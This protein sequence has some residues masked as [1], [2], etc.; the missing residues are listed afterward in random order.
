MRCRGRP[1]TRAD[2]PTAVRT[3]G[4]ATDRATPILAV[5]AGDGGEESSEFEAPRPL[6]RRSLFPVPAP[7]CPSAHLP[8]LCCTTEESGRKSRLHRATPRASWCL[9]TR[10]DPTC[11]SL[12]GYPNGATRRTLGS[13]DG[14]SREGGHCGR[15][16]RRRTVQE[17]GYAH[18]PRLKEHV[19]EV[20]SVNSA[21]DP[22]PG[23]PGGMPHVS[24]VPSHLAVCRNP[25]RFP[26]WSSLEGSPG[27]RLVRHG[28]RE[29]RGDDEW[30][31]E[32][33]AVRRL[34]HHRIDESPLVQ[35]DAAEPADAESARLRVRS[36]VH[37]VTRPDR[38][39][40]PP[41]T[42]SAMVGAA[43]P[44]PAT[45]PAPRRPTGTPP[46]YDAGE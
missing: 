30:V 41:P 7:W 17:R 43:Y 31:Q 23:S 1:A 46:R 44:L 24:G 2:R 26:E 3:A 13:A 27:G 10:G 8:S 11:S 29:V 39:P 32:P 33:T 25:E 6:G 34:P 19:G 35:Q 9:R 5:D 36:A 20:N 28:L 42:K 22:R 16:P 21:G 40:P 18:R 4:R 45:R 12:A 15:S 38:H 37:E 14:R